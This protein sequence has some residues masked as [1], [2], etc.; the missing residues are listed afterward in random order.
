MNSITNLRN[1]SMGW[2]LFGALLIT[3]CNDNQVSGPG[4]NPDI[5]NLLQ[6]IQSDPGLTILEELLEGTSLQTVLDQNGA[7]TFFAPTDAAFSNLPAGYLESLDMNQKRELLEYHGYQGS[8]RI[9]NE[10][11][12]ESITTM[13]GDPL[14]VELG[15]PFGNLL[16]NQARFIKTNTEAPNGVLH[17][18]DKVLIPDQLGTLY[19]NIYKRYE[20]KNFAARLEAADLADM[21]R[22]PGTKTLLTTSDVA[23]DWYESGEGLSFTEGEWNEIM[24][25]HVLFTD[26]TSTGQGTRMAL[27]TMHQDSVY[28]VVDQVAEF[29]INGG[30]G[31]PVQQV[32]STNGKIVLPSGIMLPD[33]F[34]GVLPILDKRF[35]YK[36]FRAA[37]A[38]AGMTGRLY[39]SNNNADEKFTLF[40][41]GDNAAGINNLPSNETQ[42]AELLQYHILL[43]EFDTDE[44]QDGQSYTSWQGKQITITRNGNQILVNGVAAVKQPQMTG[45]NGVVYV[46]DRVL[47]LPSN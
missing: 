20:F 42:L 4:Q 37:L 2:V 45:K 39:N 30:G 25:Y 12:K 9:P 41:P 13:Q 11:K 43:D 22:A 26:F 38:T 15:Q 35:N 40:V 29:L 17:T 10:I 18:I 44:L 21:L 24:Q 3:G 16:N 27:P 8:Y 36:T 32:F 6:T 33:K 28:L 1:K 14:F 5:P 23:L 34:L 47:E 46:I 7:T 19:D 31:S